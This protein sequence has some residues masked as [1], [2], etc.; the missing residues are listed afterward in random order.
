MRNRLALVITS[1]PFLLSLTLLILNDWWFK[2]AFANVIT[3]K[4]SD[5]AGVA[6]VS[7][8]LL[9]AFP[10]YSKRIFI[11]MLITFLWWKSPLS[12]SAIQFFNEF[13]FYHIDRTV[14]YTDLIAFTI[15]PVCFYVAER[16]E[17]F[18]IPW[19]RVKRV[20]YFPVVALT[21]FA[22]MGTSSIPTQHEY[23]VRKINPGEAL[24]RDAVV[25]EIEMVTKAHNIV[26]VE[27]SKPTDKGT[28][29]GS[30]LTLQYAFVGTSSIT[31]NVTAYNAGMTT[32]SATG[33]ERAEAL[34]RSLKVRL[35]ERFKGMGLEYVE[36]LKSDR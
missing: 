14:D 23:V 36:Q 6:V 16:A 15:F 22:I 1:W 9:S 2:A 8:L 32:L 10:S 7:L 19:H 12:S 30:G 25:D 21:A 3:G 28:Y 5:F 33:D 4:L 27:C 34:R 20:L 31:F 18:A 35:T 26:C 11:G 17:A 13:S 24:A 29:S